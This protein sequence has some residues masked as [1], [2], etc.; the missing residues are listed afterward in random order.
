MANPKR[1]HTRARRDSRRSSNWKLEKPQ[2]N[3]CKQCGGVRRSHA[4]CPACGFYNG[5][6]VMT[7]K[8]KKKPEGGEPQ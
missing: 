5:Q 6:S 1:K 8:T 7:I 3:T 2:V 4:V